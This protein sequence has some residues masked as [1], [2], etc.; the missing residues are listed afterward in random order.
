MCPRNASALS[1]SLSLSAVALRALVATSGRRH[2]RGRWAI[3]GAGG[4]TPAGGMRE[5][6]KRGMP[7]NMHAQPLPQQ[8]GRRQER[9]TSPR[10]DAARARVVVPGA[11]DHVEA[12]GPLH[13]MAI[14]SRADAEQGRRRHRGGVEVSSNTPVGGAARNARNARA[15]PPHRT[16]MGTHRAH[17]READATRPQLQGI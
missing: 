7:Q 9:S 5:R 13:T 1:L 10:R 12:N 8:A 11:C 14:S 2:H 3:K 6:A 17:E 16:A 15:A 4:P